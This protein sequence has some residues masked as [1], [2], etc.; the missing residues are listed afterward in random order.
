MEGFSSVSMA[1]STISRREIMRAGTAI[2]AVAALPAAISAM[3]SDVWLGAG[4]SPL[5]GAIADTIIPNT[6]TI[7]AAKAGVASFIELIVDQWMDEVQRASFIS[8]M[9]AFDDEVRHQTGVSLYPCRQSA[10]RLF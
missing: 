2:A 6:D 9:A 1:A 5:L 8:G 10:A 3:E 7:G 4:R